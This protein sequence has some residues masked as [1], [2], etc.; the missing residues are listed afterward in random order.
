MT[1]PKGLDRYKVVPDGC[2]LWQGPLSPNGYGRTSK[3]YAHRAMYEILMGPIPPR[4]VIDHLCRV[5]RC[6]NPDHMEVVTRGENVLRG[7]TVSARAARQTHCK[8]GHLLIRS[9]PPANPGSP[10]HYATHATNLYAV[11]ATSN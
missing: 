7:E 2:W 10:M 11:P 1:C 3:W 9:R 6:V 5:R 4:L 8:R